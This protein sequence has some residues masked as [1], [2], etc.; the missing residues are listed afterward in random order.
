VLREA[1]LRLLQGMADAAASLLARERQAAEIRA[2]RTTRLEAQARTDRARSVAVERER[3]AT[4]GKLTAC[5]THELNGPLAFMRTNLRVLGEHARRLA[6]MGGA[7]GP[8]PA[9]LA[10]IARDAGDIA[11]ECLEGLDRIGAMVQSLRGLVQ[12]SGRRDRFDP[13]RPISDAV[14]VFR[15]ARRD[16]CEVGLSISG[17]LP[18]VEGSPT[19]LSHVVLNLLENGLDA[20][21]GSGALQVRA[22]R[23]GAALRVEVEDRGPGIPPDVRARLFEP[24]FTTKPVGKG[25]GLG[26]YIC[27]ELVGQLGGRIAFESGPSGTVFRVEIPG[28]SMPADGPPLS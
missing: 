27:R 16:H 20:M 6:E 12:D 28:P 7:S 3:L 8:D 24:F 23:A 5:V 25:T 18:D 15:R 2:E 13:V 1:E 22:T 19:A 4:V 17:D 11:D 21:G 14:E 10:E 26:L 9:Q